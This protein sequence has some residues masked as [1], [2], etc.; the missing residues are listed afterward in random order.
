MTTPLRRI[1][2]TLSEALRF[3]LE[4]NPS[5]FGVAVEGRSHLEFSIRREKKVC[6]HLSV[7]RLKAP[8]TSR[9]RLAREPEEASMPKS[10]V[11]P[12]NWAAED[13]PRSGVKG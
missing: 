12:S 6:G 5:L 8:A 3:E 11:R 1:V 10:S 4:R 13:Q 7:T 2:A 9:E